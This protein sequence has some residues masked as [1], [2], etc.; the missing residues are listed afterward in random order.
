MNPIERMRDNIQRLHSDAQLDLIAPLRQAG[1]WTLEIDFGAV[2]MSVN[3]SERSGFG[4]STFR[5]EN[6]GEGDDEIYSSYEGAFDRICRLMTGA[7]QTSPPLTV[8]LARLR[9]ERG[10]TQQDIATKLGV[11]QSTISGMERRDDI[12]LS[13]LKKLVDALGGAVD[14]FVR[15]SDANYRLI[16]TTSSKHHTICNL[17]ATEP[18]RRPAGS[19]ERFSPSPFR[20][21][22]K[23]GG[24]KRAEAKAQQ[25][26]VTQSVLEMY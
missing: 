21:L 2:H 13:T 23:A 25:I 18:K 9:E 8:L 19:R 3:W 14:V 15:F 24:L 17:T 22:S 5:P 12:Q 4:I 11:K 20:Q 1:M 7:E 26:R 10:L 6:F 16:L